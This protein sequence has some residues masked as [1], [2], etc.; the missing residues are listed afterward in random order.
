MQ[1][2]FCDIISLGP[3]TSKPHGKCQ[4]TVTHERESSVFVYR[5]ML[6]RGERCTE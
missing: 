1:D 2:D 5:D 6:S 4:M 3:S